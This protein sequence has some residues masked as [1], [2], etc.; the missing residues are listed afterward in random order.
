MIT[1]RTAG[2]RAADRKPLQEYTVTQRRGENY[3]EI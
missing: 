3:K 1:K 2:T